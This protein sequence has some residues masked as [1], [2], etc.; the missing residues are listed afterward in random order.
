M[1]RFNIIFK[2]LITNP[3]AYSVKPKSGILI[4]NTKEISQVTI[5]I[6]MLTNKVIYFFQKKNL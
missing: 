6:K 3:Q 1:T 5:D 4:G 2:I